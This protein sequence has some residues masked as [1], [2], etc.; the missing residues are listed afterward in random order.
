MNHSGHG[1]LV[2]PVGLELAEV[3]CALGLLFLD[4]VEVLSASDLLSDL[5]LLVLLERLLE[6]RV[7]SE[8]DRVPNRLRTM[9]LLLED[10]LF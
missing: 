2:L 1:R 9:E 6:P 4:L 3:A 7:D 10:V 8:L 5:V